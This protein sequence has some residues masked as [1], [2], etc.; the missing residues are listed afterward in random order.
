MIRRISASSAGLPAEG[1]DPPGETM[2]ARL[3]GFGN[4][5]FV[6]INLVQRAIFCRREVGHHDVRPA[7]EPQLPPLAPV[8]VASAVVAGIFVRGH[9]SRA[10]AITL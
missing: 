6:G 4:T 9:T 1:L 8:Q 2:V 5:G 10:K 7:H 3:A